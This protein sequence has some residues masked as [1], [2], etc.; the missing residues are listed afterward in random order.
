MSKAEK[1]EYIR[2]A[3]ETVDEYTLEQIY[4][5]LLEMEY[6]K[7]VIRKSNRILEVWHTFFDSKTEKRLLILM[8]KEVIQSPQGLDAWRRG[9]V[10][11]EE[12]KKR[13]AEIEY[14][15]NLLKN[16]SPEKVHKLFI[17]ATVILG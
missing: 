10:S 3:L 4:E 8:R 17:G 14:I 7:D 11:K 1:V 13:D 15:I 6:W 5:F 9:N 16:A 12:I 2:T